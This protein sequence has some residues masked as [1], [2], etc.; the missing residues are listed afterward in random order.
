[1]REHTEIELNEDCDFDLIKDRRIIAFDYNFSKLN[2]TKY[3]GSL[4]SIE[5]NI[6][7][8]NSQM[9][10]EGIPLKEVNTGSN[11]AIFTN[12]RKEEFLGTGVVKSKYYIKSTKKNLKIQKSLDEDNCD[13]IKL[14]ITLNKKERI[15]F[16]LGDTPLSNDDK[17]IMYVNDN[18]F[19]YHRT[20]TEIEVF[21]GEIINA[22]NSN[23]D[24][25]ITEI[26]AS[27][28]WKSSIEEKKQLI[29]SLIKYG[30][31]RRLELYK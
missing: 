19:H 11:V 16:D 24:W 15:A 31:K 9:Y 3:F 26:L 13:L 17:W 5:S 4:I 14:N 10:L 28:E 1:M 7:K 8:L 27:R 23:E 29:S 25:F 18:V 30:I 22:K 21:R 2:R 20:S 6:L 12:Y